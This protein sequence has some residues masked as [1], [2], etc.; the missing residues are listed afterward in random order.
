M[1]KVHFIVQWYEEP[2]RVR[3]RELR[4]AMRRQ[5]ATV[6]SIFTIVAR[7]RRPSFGEM[8]SRQVDEPDVVNL[9]ANTDCYINPKDM[10]MLSEV[11]PGE[12]WCLSRTDNCCAASQDAWAWRGRLEVTADYPQG[13]PG[14]DNRFA[15]D[16][17]AA[18]RVPV[19]PALSVRVLHLHKSR[20][21]RWTEGNRLP[22][23]YLFVEPVKIGEASG[24][25][26][27]GAADDRMRLEW[28]AGRM[29]DLKV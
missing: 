24:L 18:G 20:V 19:N 5:S 21:R 22:H 14:C 7:N 9:L 2:V 3:R 12:V 25:Q 27:R 1:S 29:K 23:P 17:A 15:Y 13:L 26:Y 6:D 8:V 4:E 16:C 11:Q 10:A 28:L